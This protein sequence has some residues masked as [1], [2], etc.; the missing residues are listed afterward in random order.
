MAQVLTRRKILPI[1]FSIELPMFEDGHNLVSI[2]IY[3][4]CQF[5]WLH[6]G[7]RK[8]D[9]RSG[10]PVSSFAW[11]F[12]GLDSLSLS[13]VFVVDEIFDFVDCLDRNAVFS[14]GFDDFG[15]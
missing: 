9:I 7:F 4:R 2:S 3:F 14:A 12:D 13:E 8:I 1:D 10:S 5:D 11:M 6:R 15:R